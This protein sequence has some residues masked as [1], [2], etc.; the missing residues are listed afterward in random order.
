MRRITLPLVAGSLA[1]GA[2][3]TFSFSML[4]VSDSLV[5]AQRKEFHPIT[6]VI[7]DLVQI[8]GAGPAM[9]CAFA[10]WAML[11]L[12]AALGAAAALRGRSPMELLRD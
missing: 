10:T 2:L 7:F 6:R 1:A 5:L 3:L 11:F 8:L 12:A 4:E 9:A